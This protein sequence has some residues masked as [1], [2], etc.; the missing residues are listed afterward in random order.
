MNN[1]W[2]HGVCALVTFLAVGLFWATTALAQT[3]PAP[4][5]LP[6]E[7]SSARPA[8]FY[9]RGFDG[10]ASMTDQAWNGV[11]QDPDKVDQLQDAVLA[12]VAA[13]GVPPAPSPTALCEFLGF[14]DGLRYELAVIQYTVVG[15]CVEDGTFTGHFVAVA[16]C[17]L[18]L[19]LGG[20][21][22]DED[23]IR[24]AVGLCGASFQ[25]ACESTLDTE[26]LAFPDV[27]NGHVCSDYVVAPF[28]G[29]YAQVR[30]NQCAYSPAP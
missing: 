30:N 5:P 8:R 29:V 15:M 3:V 9:D 12:A 13:L 7:C 4:P 21:G 26:T 16:Y 6:A 20:L 28:N 1:K 27:V 10:G 22:L 17:K 18:S 25:A 14:V 2:K 11:G 24:L 23:L 19:A